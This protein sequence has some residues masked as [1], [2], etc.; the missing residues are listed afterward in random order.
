MIGNYTTVMEKIILSGMQ[1]TGYLHIGHYVG[2]LKNFLDLQEQFHCFYMIAD[3]HALTTYYRDAHKIQIYCLSMLANW[4]AVGINPNK[5]TL[6]LQSDVPEHCE[7]NVILSMYT[8]TSWL[9]RNPTYKEKKENQASDLSSYGFLGYPVLQASDIL[10][11]QADI[12][13]IGED[14]LPHL[15]ITR[16]I[17][18]RFNQFNGDVFVLPKEKLSHVPKINGI[19]GRKMS[20]SYHNTI[21][22]NDSITD[23]EQKIK[24]MVTDPQ[25]VRKE[26]PG[27]PEVCTVYDYHKIFHNPDIQ[28]I[29]EACKTAKI[30]CVECK[31][32]IATHINYMLQ[33][34]RE[35]SESYMQDPE[36]LK[37]ILQEGKEKASKYA[38]AT[39]N[40]VRQSMYTA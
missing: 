27:D 1:P 3:L 9:F 17:A 18:Q 21:N 37:Q 23:T 12:V 16:E 8:P 39:M 34:I 6:F 4:L 40:K 19:D 29:A 13:P 36:S 30:G 33:P 31:G 22:L 32:K 14:Q 24:K 2:V 15:E 25:R 35:K 7:L 38:Q 26:I 10:L 20:K 5:A 11:Y 28:S